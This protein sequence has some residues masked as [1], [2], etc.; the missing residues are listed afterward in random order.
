MTCINLVVNVFLQFNGYTPSTCWNQ[1]YERI[2][3]LE[4]VVSEGSVADGVVE[5]GYESGSDMFG[6]S[7]PEVAEL[8]KVCY[9]II[10]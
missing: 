3:K 9:L 6:F 2:K 5:S 10:C 8:I 7:K 4:K 1:V